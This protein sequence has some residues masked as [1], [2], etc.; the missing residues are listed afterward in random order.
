MSSVI[1]DTGIS[2]ALAISTYWM[3][4][5][6]LQTHKLPVR[7][8]QSGRENIQENISVLSQIPDYETLGF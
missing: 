8:V 2:M 4:L 5:I 3:D 7:L 6:A 1:V